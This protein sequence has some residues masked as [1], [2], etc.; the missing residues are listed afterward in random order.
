[1]AS[2]RALSTDTHTP[3]PAV[4]PCPHPRCA[5]CRRGKARPGNLSCPAEPA[6]RTRLSAARSGRIPKSS[7]CGA[8]LCAYSSA[9]PCS[10]WRC[11]MRTAGRL[12]WR[13]G[14]WLWPGGQVQPAGNKGGGGVE[15]DT[16]T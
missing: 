11:A 14:G 8:F 15:Q 12:R 6:G 2:C 1:M 16:P 4:P 9:W 7:V 3:R 13:G 5:A 10:S